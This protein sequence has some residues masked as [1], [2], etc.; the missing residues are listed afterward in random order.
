MDRRTCLRALAAGA[1]VLVGRPA[2][3]QPAPAPRDIRFRL[4]RDGHSIGTH[5][6]AFRQD[7][8]KTIAN[9]DVDIRVRVA[10]ITAF[11]YRHSSEEVF[12]GGRLT[13]VR[14]TTDDNGHAYGVVG[15]ATRDGFRIEG[16][17]GPFTAPATLMT[18]NSAWH[19]GFVRQ[20]ALINVQQGGQCGLVANRVG[21]ESIAVQGT[22]MTAEKYRAMTPQCAGYVWYGP[23]GRWVRAVLEM[24]GETVEYVL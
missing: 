22:A 6:V 11:H 16:P 24:R 18:S 17:G 12:E 2:W 10:F 1:V 14:S 7:G 21:S 19:S 15:Q 23:D 20:Q 3:A 13:S 5:T 9:V 8:A 4:L